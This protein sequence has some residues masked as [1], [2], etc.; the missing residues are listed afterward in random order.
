MA[1]LKNSHAGLEI[2]II[3][4]TTRLKCAGAHRKERTLLAF[5]IKVTS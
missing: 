3:I 1:S 5:G 4:Y 2:G